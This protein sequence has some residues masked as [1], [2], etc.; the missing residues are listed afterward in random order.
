LDECQWKL[1]QYIECGSGKRR[2]GNNDEDIM[3]IRFL[4]CIRNVYLLIM[5]QKL[6]SLHSFISCS[7]CKT[8]TS[9]EKE[10]YFAL[11]S[12]TYFMFEESSFKSE[13]RHIKLLTLNLKGRTFLNTFLNVYKDLGIRN[14]VSKSRRER[15]KDPR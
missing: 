4:I 5:K 13:C 9:L 10:N 6:C 11:I 14:L 3:I 7:N 15:K 1:S 2:T 8:I 12:V